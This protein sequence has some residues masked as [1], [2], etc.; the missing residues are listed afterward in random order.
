EKMRQKGFAY[1]PSIGA[2]GGFITI[3]KGAHFDA[4]VVEQNLFGHTI[5]FWSKLTSQAFFPG[6]LTLKLM[7]T[8]SGFFLLGLQEIPLKGQA[9]TWLLDSNV[10]LM[11]STWIL[12]VQ[13]AWIASMAP[14]RAKKWH[15]GFGT[16]WIHWISLI[17][18]SGTSQILQASIQQMPTFRGL[19]LFG[20]T[21]TTILYLYPGGDWRWK[22]Y[23]ITPPT[24][25]E[26]KEI[27][28]TSKNVKALFD[29]FLG[30]KNAKLDKHHLNIEKTKARYTDLREKSLENNWSKI[31]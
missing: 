13:F 1:G 31:S 8:S 10:A 28:F 16:K 24:I 18:G 20:L 3:W 15:K 4:E 11:V 25:N 17:L 7:T 29:Y 27:T 12:C 19:T 5:I 26:C 6:F 14:I 2:S 22:N 21:I 23:T 9:F 30:L